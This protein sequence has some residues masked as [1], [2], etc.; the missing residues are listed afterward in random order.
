MDRQCNRNALT[1]TSPTQYSDLVL[2]GLS[3]SPS[4]ITTQP[5]QAA[6]QFTA[7]SFKIVNNGPANLSSTTVLV[8][9]YLSSNTNFG[10]SDDVKIGDTSFPAL[11]MAANTTAQITLGST[12]LGNMVRMWPSSVV[13][14]NYYLFA[15]IT[16]TSASPTD[17][18]PANNSRLGISRAD[19]FVRTAI[20]RDAFHF[21]KVV[22]GGNRSP[23]DR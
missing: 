2:T 18:N 8:Q 9:Y 11:T 20:N 15:M 22:C 7:C 6:P 12:A 21:R 13:G 19:A 16:I 3:L 5:T 10:D 23:G 1:A 4:T 14:G 17:P